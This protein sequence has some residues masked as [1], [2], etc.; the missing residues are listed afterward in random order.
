MREIKF[1]AWDRKTREMRRV[2]QIDFPEWFVATQDGNN[3]Y[4]VERNSFKNEITDRHLLMQYTGLKDCNIEEIYDGDILEIYLNAGNIIKKPVEFY[5]GS[6][7]AMNY[8]IS[9]ILHKA[10]VIGNI[11]ENP[12]LLETK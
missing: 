12:E 4:D 2:T 7:Y 3:Y 8:R 6:Y 9:N 1:R 11:Y 5:K 10:R